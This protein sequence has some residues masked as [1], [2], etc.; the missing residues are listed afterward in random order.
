[1]PGGFLRLVDLIRPPPPADSP[2][3]VRVQLWRLNRSNEKKQARL[4]ALSALLERLKN[5]APLTKKQLPDS[6]A[7]SLTELLGREKAPLYAVTTLELKSLILCPRKQLEEHQKLLTAIQAELNAF[8]DQ[9]QKKQMKGNAPNLPQLVSDA[10]K[11]CDRLQEEEQFLKAKQE[12][13]VECLEHIISV[14]GIS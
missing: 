10:Q 3:A 14:F 6:L 4:D 2:L 12:R 8:S 5:P 7:A 11:Q 13:L 9:L 1:M